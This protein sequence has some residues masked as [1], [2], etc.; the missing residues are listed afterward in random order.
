MKH[1]L[2]GS[3]ALALTAVMALP[4]AATGWGWGSPSPEADADAEFSG[5][6]GSTGG[7]VNVAKIWDDKDV[8]VTTKPEA[9][10]NLDGGFHGGSLGVD[11]KQLN[12]L[13]QAEANGLV[14]SDAG[15][16]PEGNTLEL[17]GTAKLSGKAQGDLSFVIGETE[18]SGQMHQWSYDGKHG[19]D[20]GFFGSVE[21]SA[22]G[23][24]FAM[25]DETAIAQLSN[26]VSV[27]V[28]G[29]EIDEIDD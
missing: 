5:F 26:S 17:N 4:A 18:L 6:I 16:T 3:A 21:G 27:S 15:R 23:L 7:D 14:L 9:W 28:E 19:G 24:A 25:D 11:P 13:T 10:A 2:F 20:N 8:G 1:A 29:E 12:L 22:G